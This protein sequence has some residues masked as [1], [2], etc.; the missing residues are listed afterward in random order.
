MERKLFSLDEVEVK[1]YDDKP[2]KFAGYASVFNGVDS[3]GDTILPGAYT[4]TLKNR[5]RPILMRWQHFGPVIGKWT[6]A[7]QDEKGLRMEG[8]LTPGHSLAEDIYASMKHG[9]VN[10]LSIGY[11]PIK[12]AERPDRWTAN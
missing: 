3:Y 7:E 9:A 11:R 6:G 10:G 8:E 1:F 12:F 5:K 4:K 2:G